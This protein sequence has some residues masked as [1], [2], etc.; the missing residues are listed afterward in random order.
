MSLIT[1]VK[2]LLRSNWLEQEIGWRNN[3]D[4]RALYNKIADTQSAVHFGLCN[5]FD[6]PAVVNAMGD[7]VTYCNIYLAR[8]APEAPAVYL[9]KKAAICAPHQ[10]CGHL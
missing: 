8:P 4:D 1:A 6:T 7:L 2:A 9:L 5:N 3:G 10:Y